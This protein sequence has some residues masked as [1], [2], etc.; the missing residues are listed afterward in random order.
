[1]I[2]QVDDVYYLNYG[3]EHTLHLNCPRAV[4]IKTQLKGAHVHLSLYKANAHLL[5][6]IIGQHVL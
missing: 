3:E 4:K 6:D 5:R 2:Y 1:M